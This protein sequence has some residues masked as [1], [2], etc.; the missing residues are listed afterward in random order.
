MRRAFLSFIVLAA[1]AFV[2]LTAAGCDPEVR[3]VERTERVEE[4]EPQTVSPGQEVV[5]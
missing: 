1:P 4:S 5:E 2:L 3:T